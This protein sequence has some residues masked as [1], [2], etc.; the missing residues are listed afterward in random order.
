MWL[1]NYMHH[2]RYRSRP[3]RM[4]FIMQIE[5]FIIKDV[6]INNP[7]SVFFF[8]IL[9]IHSHIIVFQDYATI[10]RDSITVLRDHLSWRPLELPI[11]S[12]LLC[13]PHKRLSSVT[14]SCLVFY[15][16]HGGVL[17]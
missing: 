5:K 12:G 4:C 2:P 9:F 7:I 8:L 1:C 10:L 11:M 6:L 16:Y 17:Q 14:D 3:E 15:G 13:S